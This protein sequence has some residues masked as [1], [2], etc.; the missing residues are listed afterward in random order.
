MVAKCVRANHTGV[1]G[2]ALQVLSRFTNSYAAREADGGDG[3]GAVV[4]ALEA[5]A[6]GA[7]KGGRRG[8]GYAGFAVELVEALRNESEWALKIRYLYSCAIC[9]RV[10]FS[11]VYVHRCTCTDACKHVCASVCVRMYE[12]EREKVVKGGEIWLA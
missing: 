3:V 12:R 11:I 1:R 5:G 9:T 8:R 6:P 2:L 7:A 10:Y 4:A